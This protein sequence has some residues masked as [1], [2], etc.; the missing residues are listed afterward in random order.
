[1]S[2]W[3]SDKIKINNK[4]I[5][6]KKWR[7]VDAKRKTCTDKSFKKL[8][9]QKKSEGFS[10]NRSEDRVL[11]VLTWEKVAN[12]NKASNRGVR[13]EILARERENCQRS[14]WRMWIGIG[15][16]A[17]GRRM[18]RTFRPE[19]SERVSLVELGRSVGFMVRR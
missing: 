13:L 5:G 19:E 6:V 4:R 17:F 12:A 9:Q 14:E 18:E 16:K 1:M 15:F 3:H 10:G 8:W 7:C 11:F 2:M